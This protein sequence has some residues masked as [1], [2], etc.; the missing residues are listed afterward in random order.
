MKM[1][2][3]LFNGFTGWDR[4]AL[5]LVVSTGVVFYWRGVWE[6]SENLFPPIGSLVVG[7]VILLS[8]GYLTKELI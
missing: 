7:F 8:T 2:K 1:S 6:L 5:A 4:I 3:K